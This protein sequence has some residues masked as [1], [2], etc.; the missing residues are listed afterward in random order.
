MLTSGERWSGRVQWP[1]ALTVNSQLTTSMSGS[2]HSVKGHF[3]EPATSAEGTPGE[4]QVSSRRSGGGGSR[5]VSPPPAAGGSGAFGGRGEVLGGRGH[6]L[7]DDGHGRGDV[8]PLDGVDDRRVP[9]AGHHRRLPRGAVQDGHPH[10]ALESLPGLDEHGVTGEPAQQEVEGEVGLDPRRDVVVLVDQHLQRV[11]Q[12]T[13]RGLAP[14]RGDDLPDRQRL[15]RGPHLEELPHLDGGEAV[16]P[17]HAPGAGGDQAL[18]LQ[19]AQR[20]AHRAPA[21]PER[22]GQFDLA[23]VVARAVLTGEDRRTQRLERPLAQRAAVQAGQWL[24]AHGAPPSAGVLAAVVDSAVTTVDKHLPR[25]CS[26]H[27]TALTAPGGVGGPRG[28]VYRRTVAAVEVL[29]ARRPTMTQTPAMPMHMQRSG[30]DP[31]A[32][33]ARLRSDEGVTRVV[34]PFGMPAWLVTR[35]EDVREVLSDPVRFSNA[36]DVPLGDRL[37][38]SREEMARRRAGQLLSLDPPEHS[39][40]RRWLPCD[41]PVPRIRRLAP[42]IEDIVDSHPADL[43]RD[44]PPADLVSGFALPIPSLVICELLGVPYSERAQFQERTRRLLDLSVPL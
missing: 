6:V 36:T 15:H 9:V 14:R 23:Q 8:G 13:H 35:A 24:D 17:Q 3:R 12:G 11:P 27:R 37:E 4:P 22:A 25:G 43:E 19:V 2:R 44:G 28:T 1:L 38:L 34:T 21:D 10:P 39:R 40:V 18:L 26:T 31:V 16:D 7:L 33:L 20:L 5:E 41:V 30:F 29:V 42:G 32:E